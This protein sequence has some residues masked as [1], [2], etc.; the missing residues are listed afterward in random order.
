VLE[1][2]APTYLLSTSASNILNS[3]RI[4]SSSWIT[5]GDVYEIAT[6]NSTQQ[7]RN[8][9]LRIA[10]VAS[11]DGFTNLPYVHYMLTRRVLRS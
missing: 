9:K 11:S 5:E 3:T 7:S 6:S 2:K 4:F 1:I 8:P 10:P